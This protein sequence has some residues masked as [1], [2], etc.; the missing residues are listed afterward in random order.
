MRAARLGVVVNPVAGM[1]GRVALHGTDG[2]AAATAL[3]RGATPVA[4]PRARRTLARLHERLAGSVDVF[5]ASG[6]M[7]ADLLRDLGWPH[8]VVHDGAV[9]STA[10]DTRQTVSQLRGADVTLVLFVGGDGTA[11]DVAAAA[12]ADIAVLGVPAGVKMHSAVFGTSPE[13]AA[14]VAARFLTGATRVGTSIVDIVDQLDDD[15]PALV[16]TA[17]VP[18]AREQ[19]QAAKSSGSGNDDAQLAAL[20]REIAAEM[21]PGRL[22]LLGPGTTVAHVSRALR[23]PATLLGVDAVIDAALV[24]SDLT[25]A[26]LQSLLIKYS[27]AVLVLGVVGGQGFLLGR[28]NQQ[29]SPAVIAAVG[30]DNIVVLAA[31]GK[32][33]ALQP[34]V[35]RVDL[36]DAAPESALTGYR[37]VRTAPGRSTVLKIVA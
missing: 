11:R 25:E 12:G 9:P 29:L 2:T 28:G 4:A 27:D 30:S 7:G 16:A 5:T 24:G 1:G 15:H 37:L 8:R 21:V 13:A 22:Y 3:E 26:Q 33:A 18:A 19:L 20:G 35:L 23:L 6:A 31:A 10:V 17:R 32:V 14:D 34:P 36:G